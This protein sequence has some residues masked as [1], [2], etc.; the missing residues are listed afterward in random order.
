MEERHYIGKLDKVIIGTGDNI[1]EG[2]L[3]GMK[4]WVRSTTPEEAMWSI[5]V[6][7]RGNPER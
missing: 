1:Y 6:S 7:G 2:F 4:V 5:C 3:E